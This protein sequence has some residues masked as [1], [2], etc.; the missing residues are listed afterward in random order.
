MKRSTAMES[1]QQ[2]LENQILNINDM[3]AYCSKTL[4]NVTSQ[5]LSKKELKSHQV[6]L[7]ELIGLVSLFTYSLAI[8]AFFIVARLADKPIQQGRKKPQSAVLL[9]KKTAKIVEKPQFCHNESGH[10]NRRSV[11]ENHKQHWK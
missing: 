11:T 3:V 4:T 7:K 8:V 9:S 6:K 1:L 5:I 10:V 2:P